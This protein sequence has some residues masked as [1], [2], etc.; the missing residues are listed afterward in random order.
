MTDWQLGLQAFHEGRMR[1]AA[2]RLR[3][4]LSENEFAVSQTARY[5]TC[6]YLGA[7]L[8]AQ[9]QPEEAITAF[10]MAFRFSPSAVPSEELVMNLAHAYLASGRREAA[11]EALR[12]LL[13]H[14]PGHVAASMLAL[15]L[16][17]S[18]A[19]ANVK[20]AVLGTSPETAHNYIRTL[21][22]TQSLTQGYDPAQ[23][24]A[25]LNQLERFVIDLSQELQQAGAKIAEYELE[26]MRYQQM[27]DA[28]VENMVQMQRNPAQSQ[29]EGAKTELSPIELLF[30]QKS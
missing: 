4:A 3:A 6:A 29:Q 10:E 27:E 21:T 9:G 14:T 24:H 5:E 25:A 22:F 30:Q 8:Y 16:D 26:I 13:F 18:S 28:V 11:R 15:R 12:F 7:A 20:G 17:S 19:D 23:V 2:D 1:E